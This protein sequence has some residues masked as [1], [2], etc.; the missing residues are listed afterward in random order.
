MI[1][2]PVNLFTEALTW[3]SES[4]L[5]AFVAGTVLY[6]VLVSDASLGW[7]EGWSFFLELTWG[8]H[9]RAMS[10]EIGQQAVP[11]PSCWPIFMS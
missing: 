4:S 10:P 11:T 8:D 9:F 7:V 2:T 3:A 5:M 6:G 1:A